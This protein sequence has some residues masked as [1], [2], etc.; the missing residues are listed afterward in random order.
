MNDEVSFPVVL[1][2]GTVHKDNP[3]NNTYSSVHRETEI[4]WE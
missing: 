1:R 4:V 3:E 2:L